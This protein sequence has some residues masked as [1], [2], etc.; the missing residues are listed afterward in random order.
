MD[1]VDIGTNV[2]ETGEPVDNYVGGGALSHPPHPRIP[3]GFH[4]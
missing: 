3:Q 2:W 4:K 1:P